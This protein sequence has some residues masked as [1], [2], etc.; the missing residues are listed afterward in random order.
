MKRVIIF[1]SAITLCLWV[2]TQSE[3]ALPTGAVAQLREA[4]FINNIA[5]SND[6]NMLAVAS[7]GVY[8]YN[9]STFVE[10]EFFDTG[11]HMNSVAFGQDDRLL[12]SGGADNTVKL[13]DTSSR[14]L[15]GTLTGHSSQVYSVA[16]SPDGRLLASGSG[17]NTIKLW[18]TSSRQLVGTLTGHS[19]QVYSVAFSPDGHLLASG[20]GD[21]TLKGWDAL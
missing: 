12:A 4:G 16:F 15:V 19:S 14:Q 7:S 10:I 8:L 6:G 5:F 20:S 9:P 13:W 1:I 17:D 2:C 21:N 18:D 3:S 11:V